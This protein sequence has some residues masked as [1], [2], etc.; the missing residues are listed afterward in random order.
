[1]PGDESPRKRYTQAEAPSEP[2]PALAPHPHATDA[3]KARLS[4]CTC[5]EYVTAENTRSGGR[6]GER[7]AATRGERGRHA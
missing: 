5:D 2:V 1:M 6:R 4:C 7:V 3:Q